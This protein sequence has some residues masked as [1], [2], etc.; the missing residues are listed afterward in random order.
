MS[1]SSDGVITFLTAPD[2]ENPTDAN[3]DNIYEGVFTATNSDGT[4][5]DQDI[6]ITIKDID[7]AY[8]EELSNQFGIPGLSTNYLVHDQLERKF[9]LYIP[10]SYKDDSNYPLLL[11]FHGGGSTAEEYL[12]I[13]DMRKLSED[14]GFILCLSLIHI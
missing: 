9:L 2:Y 14:K 5:L 3:S 4:S 13:A 10:S 8:Q 7:E 11:N 6:F 12:N 1:V